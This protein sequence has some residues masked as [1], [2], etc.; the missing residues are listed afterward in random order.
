MELVKGRRLHVGFTLNLYAR[1]PLEQGPGPERRA[2]AAKVWQ[3]LREI[4]DSLAPEPGGR[5]RLEVEAPRTAAFLR[6][7]SQM[8]PEIGLVARVFH[9][10]DYLAEVTPEERDQMGAVGRRLTEMGLKQGHW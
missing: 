1:M 3:G 9:G 8:R 2:D 7:E 6:P 10:D 5:A 4:A